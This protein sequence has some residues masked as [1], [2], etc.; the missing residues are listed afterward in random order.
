MSQATK[1]QIAARQ[2]RRL[3]TIRKQLLEMS[4]QWEDVD[5]FNMNELEALA[6]R[7]E[8]VAVALIEE[9]ES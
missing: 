2:V 6:D 7:A 4:T 8:E 1:K 3:R 9:P 5:Q